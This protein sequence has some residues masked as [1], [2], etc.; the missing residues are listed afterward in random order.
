ME[1]FPD[2]ILIMPIFLVVAGVLFYCTAVSAF[3]LLN[4]ENPPAKE[5]FC[6]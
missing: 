4:Q 2:S 3:G 5:L 6:R 1:N